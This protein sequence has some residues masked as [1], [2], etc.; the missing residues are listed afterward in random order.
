MKGW[1]NDYDI[2]FHLAAIIGV[3]HV[4]KKPKDVLMQNMCLLDNL[5]KIA[6]KQ[7]KLS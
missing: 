1:G 6:F 5:I 7:K 4:N 2:I 3:K